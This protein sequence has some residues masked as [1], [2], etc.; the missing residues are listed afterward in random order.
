MFFVYLNI[1]ME[2]QDKNVDITI[3]TK[4]R[5]YKRK[6]YYT[7]SCKKNRNSLIRRYFKIALFW[8]PK[9][10]DVIISLC[11][12]FALCDFYIRLQL[13]IIVLSFTLH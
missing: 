8:K 3:N 13:Y 12:L 5:E 1:Y 7:I 9:S 2:E 10:T 6:L 11:V 4:E